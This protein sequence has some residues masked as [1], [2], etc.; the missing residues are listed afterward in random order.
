MSAGNTSLASRSEKGS[1]LIPEPQSSKGR[2]SD[3]RKSMLEQVET[4]LSVVDQKHS[5]NVHPSDFSTETN[6]TIQQRTS[7]SRSLYT[8]PVLTSNNL[9]VTSGKPV[10][11]ESNRVPTQTSVEAGQNILTVSLIE[12]SEQLKRMTEHRAA[13]QIEHPTAPSE[14]QTRTNRMRGIENLTPDSVLSCTLKWGPSWLF[15][16]DKCNIG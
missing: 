4:S 14:E 13:K 15:E 8:R 6:E 5:E 12:A 7:T 11:R 9:G 16:Y 2:S 10:L 3:G 1:S